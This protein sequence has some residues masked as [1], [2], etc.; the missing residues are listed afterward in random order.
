MNISP[1][2]VALV[3]TPIEPAGAVVVVELAVIAVSR[4][5]K[6]APV[7][8]VMILPPINLAASVLPSLNW[9][10]PEPLESAMIDFL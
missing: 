3:V 8:A 7:D 4:K 10:G 1:K 6:P 9:Y 2:P 5:Y